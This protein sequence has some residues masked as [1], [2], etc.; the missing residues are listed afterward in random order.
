M[1]Q[2]NRLKVFH[3]SGKCCMD[4][5]SATE[6]SYKL[7]LDSARTGVQGLRFKL[8]FIVKNSDLRSKFKPCTIFIHECYQ[9]DYSRKHHYYQSL[10]LYES[11]KCHMHHKDIIWNLLERI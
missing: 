2:G 8:S 5:R 6:D 1:L 11:D 3:L 4:R 9:E 7:R 10:Y